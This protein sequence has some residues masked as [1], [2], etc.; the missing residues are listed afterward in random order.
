MK[1]KRVTASRPS[2]GSKRRRT[3]KRVARF[4]RRRSTI[5]QTS[6]SGVGRK[7]QYRGRRLG[8]R[9]IRRILWRDT[10]FSPH[11]RSVSAVSSTIASPASNNTATNV[12][13]PLLNYGGGAFWTAAG[14]A[15]GVDVSQTV[16]LFDGDITIRGG[17]VGA[18]ITNGSTTDPVMVNIY[19]LWSIARP[20]FTIVSS[21]VSVGYD[22][23]ID[24][25]VTTDVG[26]IYWSSSVLLTP[27]QVFKF[28][29]KL[30]P[31]KIDRHAYNN[32][33][34]S[35]Q[36]YV[37]V[38]DTLSATASSIRVT[39]YYNLSFVGDSVGTT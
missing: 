35:P 17:L 29:R 13:F 25:D 16:P 21:T 37:S 10:I 2:W 9:A 23:T 19:Y 32:G 3:G 5:T 6:Q 20:D 15:K 30:K 38:N 27:G 4:K 11:Y 18:T 8:K 7:T 36:L 24:P 12:R 34:R 28:E 1:R 26:K 14:G 39:T 31:M 22:P 33:G